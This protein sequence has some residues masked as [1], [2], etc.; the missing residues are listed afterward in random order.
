[1]I[2]VA[3]CLFLILLFGGRYDVRLLL[4]GCGLLLLTGIILLFSEPGIG[5]TVIALSVIVF[6]VNAKGVQ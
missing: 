4:V 3:V 1:M 6:A 2:Y 5:V